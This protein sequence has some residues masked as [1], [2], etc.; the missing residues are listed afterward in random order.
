MGLSA[1]LRNFRALL[2]ACG[3]GGFVSPCETK[4]FVWP[5]LKSLKS[6]GAPNQLFRGFLCYQGLEAGFVSPRSREAFAGRLNLSERRRLARRLEAAELI[7]HLVDLVPPL[8][9][10]AFT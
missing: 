6:L 8:W 9:N 7:F 3:W 4:R 10:P 5:P 2:C 1:L